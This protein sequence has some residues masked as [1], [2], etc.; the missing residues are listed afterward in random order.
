MCA[1][2]ALLIPQALI[3]EVKSEAIPRGSYTYLPDVTAVT[4]GKEKSKDYLRQVVI[5]AG[6]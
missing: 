1:L 3:A 2:A 4:K 5:A 6:S